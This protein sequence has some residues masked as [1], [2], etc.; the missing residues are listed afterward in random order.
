[1]VGGVESAVLVIQMIKTRKPAIWNSGQT[2]RRTWKV[3][4]E[5]HYIK[6]GSAPHIKSYFAQ[7]ETI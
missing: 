2:A 7:N 4:P 3:M 6:W 5:L 1:M